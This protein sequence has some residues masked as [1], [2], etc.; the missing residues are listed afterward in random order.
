M[1][2]STATNVT[3]LVFNE[4]KAT[5]KERSR[6]WCRRFAYCDTAL[7]GL[8]ASLPEYGDFPM[9]PHINEDN[10]VADQAKFTRK[11]FP[12]NDPSVQMNCPP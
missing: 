7:F 12:R 11:S 2:V 5:A 4:A 8:M 10:V 9:L 6:L 3:T 1:A